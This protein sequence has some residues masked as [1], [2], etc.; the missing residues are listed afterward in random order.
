MLLKIAQGVFWILAVCLMP[1][2]AYGE[3]RDV[4]PGNAAYKVE[5]FRGGTWEEIF[6][7]NARVSDYAGNPEAGYTQYTMGFALFTDSFRQPLKVRVTR[8][9][10]TFSKVE[11]RP[12]SYG[13]VPNVQTPNSVEFELGDPAQKVSVEFD[14][15]RME[16]LF[17][18]PDLPDTA[19][20]MGANVTYFGPGVH[21]AGVIRIANESG[22]I[23]YLDEGAVVLG[24]IEAENAA[25]LTIRGRGVFCSSQEDHG[26]GRRP[27]MEF[28]NCDNLKIEGILLRDTPN[29]TLKIVGSTG[30]HIDNIKE[31]GWI[32]NSDGMDFICCRDVLVE[33]TFQRNYDDN[34]TI[35]AFNATPEYIASHTNTDG[36]YS[37]GAI[38]M[39]AGLRDFEVCN[40]EIRNCVFWAD[41]AHNMLV[42]P[43]ARGIAFRN[44]RFHDN[45]V[46]ENRQDDGI[47]PGAMAVMIADNG[48][49]E[50]IAFEN[51]IVEDIDGGKVFC[52]H[53]TNAW[54][55][56]GLYGQWARNITLRNIAYTGT[57]AT[58]SWIRGR[59]DAQSI[60]GV[61]IGNFTVN[62][63]PVTDGSGPHLEI[64]EYVRNVT[65]E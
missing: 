33:N 61:T 43:E 62:G 51:I 28:R 5:V 15:N 20:P 36:S 52:A 64:N 1:G 40:Y 32:M 31:I 27:Q 7:Y 60:D 29:W 45:I 42:G 23:L 25:N 53:F 8:R 19:I 2:T 57:R 58:P 35:K 46:L 14:G 18:L 63:T 4:L 3:G 65:F 39:V 38:W 6:V 22:R 24:R 9:A 56:D 17:I 50:D 47:Y 34:V 12:L 55:F 44:I 48:T 49:F 54:A 13:I 26:A 21:N 16:N 41:K 30:V 10:G 11:I 37:D 59:N